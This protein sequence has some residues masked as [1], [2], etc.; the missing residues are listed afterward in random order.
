[1][2]TMVIAQKYLPENLWSLAEKF[3]I[4][5]M[6][7]E[8]YG[9]LVQLILESKSLAENNEK[10][11]WFDILPIMKSEQIDKL[12]D[13]LVREKQQLAEIDAKYKQKQEEINQKYQKMFDVNIYHKTQALLESKENEHREKDMEDADNL[14]AQM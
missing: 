9:E 7:F 14:L 12:K 10:Q 5:D 11:T 8:N 1:M 6:I 3:D 4:S 13:I 2:T